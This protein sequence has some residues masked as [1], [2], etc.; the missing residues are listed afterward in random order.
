VL[1]E[2][3]VD[4]VGG[5]RAAFEG[6]ADRI[7][8]CAGLVEGGTTPSAGMIRAVLEATRL[9]VMV[10]IRPRG[11]DYCYDRDELRTMQYEL[12]AVLQHPVAGIV[13]GVLTR[14][15][16]IDVE[17][18]RSLCR[19]ASHVSK[20]F[21][22]AFDQTRDAHQALQQLFSLPIDRLLSSGQ[23]ATALAGLPLLRE[24]VQAGGK[25]LRIMPGAGIRPENVKQIVQVTGAREIHCSASELVHGSSVYLR[26]EVPLG[27]SSLPRDGDR[28]AT[29][30]ACLRAIRDAVRGTGGGARAVD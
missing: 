27:A 24:L 16:Q 19:Q 13:F 6:G 29:S 20:T 21:H 1:L 12:D 22:R 30:A 7:E 10:M 17:A 23:Q 14:E 11:G 28:R 25:R 18:C 8:L 3:C 26:R 9:P 5:A 4:S 15:G 2:V